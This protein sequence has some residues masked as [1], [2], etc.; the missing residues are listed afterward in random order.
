MEK[1]PVEQKSFYFDDNEIKD[2]KNVCNILSELNRIEYA[3]DIYSIHSEFNV[4][5]AKLLILLQLLTRFKSFNAE[6]KEKLVDTI[7]LAIFDIDDKEKVMLRFNIDIEMEYKEVILNFYDEHMLISYISRIDGLRTAV[8]KAMDIIVNRVKNIIASCG[9][10]VRNL[11]TK[12]DDV[13]SKTQIYKI[14]EGLI[15]FE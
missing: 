8:E 6:D 3:E 10:D 5:S 7:K 1:K 11:N 13:E 2:V 14:L 12:N 15:M 9:G 4:L